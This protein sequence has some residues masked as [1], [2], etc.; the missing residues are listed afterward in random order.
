MR[1]AA[2]SLL[3][4]GC[5]STPDEVTPP[6]DVVAWPQTLA[7]DSERPAHIEGPAD[8]DQSEA[9]PLV[10][11]L[12]DVG[13]AASGEHQEAAFRLRRQIEDQRFLYL[14]PSGT[15]DSA[16]DVFWNATFACC[17]DEGLAPDDS[18]YLA[19]L[20]D[21]AIDRFAVD[22]DRVSF[23]GHG[24]GHFMAYRMACDHA[25]LVSAVAGLGGATWLDEGEC[26]ASESVSTLHVHGDRDDVVVYGGEPDAYPGAA[27]TA[28]RWSDRAGCA[29]LDGQAG[30]LDLLDA[31]LQEI[32]ETR[33]SVY[34]GCE[35]AAV[36]LWTLEGAG[37]APDVSDRFGREVIG[38]LLE[39]TR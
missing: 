24:N 34:E 25:D 39:Q 38:W 28:F 19:D 11:L 20:V 10:V 14:L 35:D 18:E 5:P 1:L 17:D 23:V 27:S 22:V 6:P 16:G 9:L 36:E 4:L 8:Q 15:A 21:E 31:S 2:L 37:H 30:R 26:M 29:S 32:D 12:H 7:V 33:R 3:L 13:P